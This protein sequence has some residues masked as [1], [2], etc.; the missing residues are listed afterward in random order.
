[1]FSKLR[2]RHVRQWYVKPAATVKPQIFPSLPLSDTSRQ[3]HPGKPDLVARGRHH[4]HQQQQRRQPS[5]DVVVVALH[6]MSYTCE[7]PD[8]PWSVRAYIHT[9]ANATF[10]QLLPSPP[11]A[12]PLPRPPVPKRRPFVKVRGIVTLFA[13]KAL[14]KCLTCTPGQ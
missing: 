6:V 7:G 2:I 1:M 14:T 8:Q 11:L 12:S 4:H 3:A 10:G 9:R 5:S 13:Q